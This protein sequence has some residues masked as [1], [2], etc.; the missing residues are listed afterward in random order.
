MSMVSIAADPADASA[1]DGV[2]VALLPMTNDWCK[3]ELPHLTLVYV[4][5]TEDLKP[6]DFNELAK[7]AS[8]LASLSSSLTVSV[9]GVKQFG[10]DNDK[11]DALDLRPTPELWAMRRALESWNASQFPFNPHCTIGPVGSA[12]TLDFIP[13]ALAFDKIY[14]GWGT[15]CLTFSLR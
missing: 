14:V 15:E 4:G 3:I 5:T 12:A 8:M 10:P 9:I 1:A 6:G 7:D 11:V 13:R 2:M